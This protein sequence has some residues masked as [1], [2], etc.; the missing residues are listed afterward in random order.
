MQQ[1]SVAAGSAAGELDLIV[2]EFA[3]IVVEG[4]EQ[5]FEDRKYVFNYFLTQN[6]F[7]YLY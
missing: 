5:G 3:I 4:Y 7:H 6:Y 2:L 1:C